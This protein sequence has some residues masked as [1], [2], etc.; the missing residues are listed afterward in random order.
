MLSYCYS[1]TPLV[2]IGTFATVF[3][4]PW[5]GGVL[6]LLIVMLGS[7]VLLA[8]LVTAVVWLPLRVGRA[9]L[10]M[11]QTRISATGPASATAP[12]A[13]SRERATESIP[14]AATTRLSG[15][16]SRRPG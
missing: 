10:R 9:I 4:I 6:A 11:S 13:S 7:V 2:V 15:A 12:W 3:A 8:G 14:V 5:F 16:R 1:W